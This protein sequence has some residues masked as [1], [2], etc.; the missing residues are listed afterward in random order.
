MAD[1]GLAADPAAF[2]KQRHDL[3]LSPITEEEIHQR[4]GG[5]RRH[6]VLLANITDDAVL[7]R[8]DPLLNRL[9]EFECFAA[10]PTRYLH[11]T[12]KVVGDVVENPQDETEFAPREE[13]E[14]VEEIDSALDGATPFTVEA[15]RLNLFPDVVYAEIADGGRFAELNRRVRSVP[16]V[17]VRD[18]DHEFIPHLT[19]GHFTRVGGYDQLLRYLKRNRSLEVPS[20]NVS[21]LELVALDFSEGRFPPYETVRTYDLSDSE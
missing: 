2:W 15:P 6:L 5:R 10:A 4:A 9:D 17:P 3:S 18:R 12:V 8:I 16:R 13:A 19:L 1:D 7:S 21:E 11:V 14:L 20:V